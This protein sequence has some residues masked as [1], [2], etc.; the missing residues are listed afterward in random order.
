MFKLENEENNPNLRYK[1]RIVGK[2]CNQKKDIDFE[3]IFSSV[4][5][6]TSIR[7]FGCKAFVHIPKDERAKLDAKVKECIY[8]GSP[9]D[10]LGFKLWDPINK[11]IVQSRDVIFFED[12]TIHD[13]ERPEKTKPI[14]RNS[15]G[16][17]LL[18]EV[19]PTQMIETNQTEQ[20]P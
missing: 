14:V 6:T 15:R 10:E 18:K 13:I 5:K 3:E 19:E 1:A 16:E 11:K 7:V 9:R 20:P 17:T 4:V 12:Q 2:G 8:L